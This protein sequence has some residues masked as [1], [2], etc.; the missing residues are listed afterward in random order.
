[1]CLKTLY[2]FG[3]GWLIN[4]DSI[5]RWMSCEENTTWKKRY[6]RRNQNNKLSLLNLVKNIIL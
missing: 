6:I 5:F 4:K 2:L 1:M 3:N